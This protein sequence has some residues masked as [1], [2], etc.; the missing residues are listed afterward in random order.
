MKSAKYTKCTCALLVLSMCLTPG[1]LTSGSIMAKSKA[2]PAVKRIIMKVGDTKSIRIKN[3]SKKASYTFISSD[4][5]IATVSKNGSVSGKKP[6]SA[7]ITV[8]EK[9]KASKSKA[10][11][12]GTINVK[13]QPK[14]T[15]ATPSP[16]LQ[17]TT[18]PVPTAPATPAPSTTPAPTAK[19]SR[20]PVVIEDPTTPDGFDAVKSSVSYGK[21]EKISYDSTTVGTTRHAYVITPP[22]YDASSDTKYPVMYLFH[23]GNGDENDWL[24]GKPS[25]ILQNLVSEGLA[26]EMILVLPNCRAREN[27]KKDPADSLSH[28]HMDAW[29]NFLYDFKNDLMPYINANYNVFTDREHTAVAGLSMGGRTALYVGFSMPES[30]SY[31]GAFSPAFGIFEYEN[32]GLHEDGYFT[33]ETFT[34][35]EE[36]MG[37]TTCLIMNGANDTMVRDEPERYHNALVANGVEHCYYLVPGDHE[38]KVWKNG[39]YNFLK[40]AFK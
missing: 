33:P 30:I 8:K 14:N 4:K 38:M 32:W 18:S 36:Y 39:L 1:I 10:R 7:K 26:E 15:A 24:D 22:D 9:M 35:P 28:E 27:D 6:G 31:I 11:K 12:I 29:T 40:I 34:F 37:Y 21:P 25:Q 5:K 17:A 23:G 20:P 19:A 13:I 3:K 16:V 2:K